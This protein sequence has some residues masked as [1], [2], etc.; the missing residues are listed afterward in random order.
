MY[1]LIL[2]A[3]LIYPTKTLQLEIQKISMNQANSRIVDYIKQ[4]KDN[5]KALAS[6]F[7]FAGK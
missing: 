4:I 1:I 2:L 7:F 3:K 5:T 6:G